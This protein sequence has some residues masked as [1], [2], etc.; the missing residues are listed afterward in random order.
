MGNVTAVI[1]VDMVDGPSSKAAARIMAESGAAGLAQ[2]L[3]EFPD[4]A[5]RIQHELHSLDLLSGGSPRS[6]AHNQNINLDAVASRLSAKAIME[7]SGAGGLAQ[8]LEEHPE[9]A[10]RIQEEMRNLDMLS[11]ASPRSTE[12]VKNKVRNMKSCAS[13]VD[14]TQTRLLK[15]LLA[16][17]PACS[18]ISKTHCV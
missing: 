13:T 1:D 7:Q 3:A 5:G 6:S 10:T 11:G 17:V 12:R 4:Q 15:V 8:Y 18:N 14:K 2:F 9:E 16:L